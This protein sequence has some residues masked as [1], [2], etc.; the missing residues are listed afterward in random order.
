MEADFA[1][2]TCK[3]AS[4]AES[5]SAGMG[6]RQDAQE[7]AQG[8]ATAVSG[9]VRQIIEKALSERVYVPNGVSFLDCMKS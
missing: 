8:Q 6:A 5:P 2:A 4:S 1:K 7:R 9:E 3:S